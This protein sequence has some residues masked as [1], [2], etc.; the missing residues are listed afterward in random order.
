[1]NSAEPL[2]GSAVETCPYCSGHNI[3]RKGA[4]KKKLET[5]QLYFC[6]DCE[7]VFTPLPLQQDLSRAGHPPG[8]NAV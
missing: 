8:R 1:M 5:V 2:V 4:R 3:V 7:K 6:N